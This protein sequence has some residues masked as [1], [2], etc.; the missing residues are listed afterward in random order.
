VEVEVALS[1]IGEV[2]MDPA[3]FT[4]LLLALAPTSHDTRQAFCPCCR[5]RFGMFH[6][7]CG[8]AASGT[9]A[10]NG[11]DRATI[12]RILHVFRWHRF[13]LRWNEWK[14][15]TDHVFSI[16]ETWSVPMVLERQR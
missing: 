12:V 11:T 8:G 10:G 2:A 13:Y 4:G 6:I 3:G 9:T 1:T 7:S 5:Y 16:E 15:G 14:T